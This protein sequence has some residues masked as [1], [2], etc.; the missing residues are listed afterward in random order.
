MEWARL[1]DESSKHIDNLR[2]MLPPGWDGKS[3][4]VGEPGRGATV[5][6]RQEER[7]RT[8]DSIAAKGDDS[9]S[10][11]YTHTSLSFLLGSGGRQKIEHRSLL[12]FFLSDA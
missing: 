10:P 8:V 7:P 1:K 9:Q 3:Q 4:L 5:G 6:M 12:K 2:N 11:G